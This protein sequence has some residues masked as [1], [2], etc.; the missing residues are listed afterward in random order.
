MADI[1]TENCP[2]SYSDGCRHGC[3]QTRLRAEYDEFR[4][5]L[6]GSLRYSPVFVENIGQ[7]SRN[8]NIID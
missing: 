4:D 2:N 7:S 3:N 1:E 6:V 5:H 8:E